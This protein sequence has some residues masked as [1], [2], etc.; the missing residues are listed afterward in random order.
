MMTSKFS[1]SLFSFLNQ[2]LAMMSSYYHIQ[3]ELTI[4]T[5]FVVDFCWQYAEWITVQ[6]YAKLTICKMSCYSIFALQMLLFFQESGKQ[7]RRWIQRHHGFFLLLHLSINILNC[8]F[9]IYYLQYI[10]TDGVHIAKVQTWNY[11]RPMMLRSKLIVLV[12]AY[13]IIRP[14]MSPFEANF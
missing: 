14:D 7:E 9:W 11:S 10:V 6:Q 8:N 12:M 3:I 4:R 13:S 1:S 2:V 5:F